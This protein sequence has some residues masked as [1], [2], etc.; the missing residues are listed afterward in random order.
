MERTLAQKILPGLVRERWEDF[1][2]KIKKDAQKRDFGIWAQW[3]AVFCG[4]VAIA[5]GIGNFV[6]F[7][8]ILIFIFAALSLASGIL[9]FL[10]EWHRLRRVFFACFRVPEGLEAY[11]AGVNGYPKRAGMYAVLAAIQYCSIIINSTSLIA[12]AVL[13]T[14]LSALNLAAWKQNGDNFTGSEALGGQ[15]EAQRLDDERTLG[16]SRNPFATLAAGTATVA[17]PPPM[18][19]GATPKTST[20]PNVDDRTQ[21]QPD[22]SPYGET[23]P[24]PDRTPRIEPDQPLRY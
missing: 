24:Y 21:L 19:D 4:F 11:I 14:I 6:D 10:I 2:D 12:V 15:G 1:R 23:S 5:L 13:F 20:S 18:F 22:P 9:V 8:H 3:G 17:T 16:T 7:R